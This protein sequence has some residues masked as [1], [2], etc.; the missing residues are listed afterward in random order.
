MSNSVEE[1]RKNLIKSIYTFLKRWNG[2]E[3]TIWDYNRSHS[4]V[5]IRI[6]S[7]EKRGNLHLI[8]LGSESM[9]GPFRWENCNFEVI[10]ISCGDEP[11]Y[12][13]VDNKAK[14]KIEAGKIEAKENCKPI[15]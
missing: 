5:T 6:T 7:K 1:Y 11:M 12:A 9:A 15:Y 4:S 13:L 8:C 10:D 2:G 14:F 3:V